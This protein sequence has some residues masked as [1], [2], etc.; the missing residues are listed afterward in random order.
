MN[1]MAVIFQASAKPEDRPFCAAMRLSTYTGAVCLMRG[2]TKTLHLSYDECF[3][4][5]IHP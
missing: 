5:R 3:S 1:V 4:L 2:L